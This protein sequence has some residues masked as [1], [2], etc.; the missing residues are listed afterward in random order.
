MDEPYRKC[1]PLKKGVRGGIIE[2]LRFKMSVSGFSFN[3]NED[4][5]KQKV[6]IREINVGIA[7]SM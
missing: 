2:I 1:E 6:I 7:I 4:N 3:V 5:S